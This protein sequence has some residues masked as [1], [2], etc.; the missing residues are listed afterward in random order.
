[1]SEI[2]AAK[3][4]NLFDEFI[5][6]VSSLGI[7]TDDIV[8]VSKINEIL[9]TGKDVSQADGDL[10]NKLKAM[11]YQSLRAGSVNYAPYTH[12]LYLAELWGC[13][14]VYSRKYLKAIDKKVG[15]IDGVKSILDLGCGFGVTTAA[16]KQMYPNAKVV[17]TNVDNSRQM[18]V[19][20]IYAEKYDF[21]VTT[22][23]PAE[24]VDIVFAS[25]FFEHLQEP[26]SY[27][28]LLVETT[29][30]KHLFVANAFGADALG[31]FD[32]YTINGEIVDGKSVSRVFNKALRD[33][34]YESKKVG[35]WNSRPSWFVKTF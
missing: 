11:W 21:T 6:V 3:K 12:D 26:I 15:K 14:W 8:K 23:A 35:F 28:K 5:G 24:P 1:M 10:A 2:L 16:L 18:D 34:G 7:P 4:R 27:L 25:E 29:A 19:A 13:F 30:P 20:K 33:L 17:G 9:F 32:T 31:H 22:D